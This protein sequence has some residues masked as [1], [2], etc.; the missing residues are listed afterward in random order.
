MVSRRSQAGEV[1]I[2]Y[3]DDDDEGNRGGDDRS[4]NSPRPSINEQLLQ[5]VL[6]ETLNR[7]RECPE[8]L[9]DALRNY[10]SR[11][12][13]RACD[14]ELFADIVREVLRHRL[15]RRTNKF[16]ADLFDEVG[17]ALWSNDDSRARVERLWNSLGTNA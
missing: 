6:G 11:H 5:E 10:Y 8:E 13:T 9:V 14:E 3:R 2:H 4:K 7:S 12:R 1:Y 16:P 15:G 17:R